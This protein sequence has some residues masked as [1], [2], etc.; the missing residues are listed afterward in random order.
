MLGRS[1]GIIF[2]QV[3]LWTESGTVLLLV[4]VRPIDLVVLYNESGMKL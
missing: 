3:H 1:C 4:S 2:G